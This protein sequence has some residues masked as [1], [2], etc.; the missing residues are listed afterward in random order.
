MTRAQIADPHLVDKIIEGCE[1]EI[2]P[3]AGATYCL[4]CIYEAGEALCLHNAATSREATMPH[5]IEC[6][7]TRRRVVIVGADPAGLEAARVAGERGHDVT[8]LEAMPWAGGQI[9]LA[10]RNPRRTDWMGIIDWR[11]SELDRLSVDV[12]SDTIADAATVMALDPDVVL[13]ATGGLPQLPDLESG[14]DRVSSSWDV[15]GGDV[16]PTGSVFFFDETDTRITLNQRLL[17]VRQEAG[18]LCVEIGSD[19]SAH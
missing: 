14:A 1:S 13:V 8:V 6:A 3:C 11:V 18:R 5:V 15:L 10:V 19:H 9:R 17:A 12:R 16:T 4:D 7:T 2:R